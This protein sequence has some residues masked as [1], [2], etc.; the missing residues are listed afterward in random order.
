LAGNTPWKSASSFVLVL[1]SWSNVAGAIARQVFRTL[2]YR[3]VTIIRLCDRGVIAVGMDDFLFVRAMYIIENKKR[4][5]IIATW[6][7]DRCMEEHNS[8][9][10]RGDQCY[11]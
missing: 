1:S 10:R 6:D 9:D 11:T 3:P 8:T 2:Q 7:D 5:N 4:R